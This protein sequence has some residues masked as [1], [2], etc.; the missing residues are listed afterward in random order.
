MFF[1]FLESFNLQRPLLII[2]FYHQ[3]KTPISFWRRQRL[4]P[5][6]LIQP[7][8]TLPVELTKTHFPTQCLKI[9]VKQENLIIK[10]TRSIN[11]LPTFLLGKKISIKKEK[12]KKNTPSTLK[13]SSHSSK[14]KKSTPH[15]EITL[16]THHKQKLPSS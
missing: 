3:I 9:Q 5:R 14:R 15:V 12:K 16:S 1:F 13:H 11:Y 6:S 4:N 8:A 10:N 7:S 2:V